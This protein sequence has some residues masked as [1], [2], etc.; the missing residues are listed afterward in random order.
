M[1]VKL[2]KQLR[3]LFVIKYYPSAGIYK[4]TTPYKT[5][6]GE[7]EYVF[8]DKDEAISNKRRLILDFGRQYYSRYRK[9][10]KII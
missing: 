1:K 10:I 3:E 6:E 2:L 9:V 7:R 8:Y 4:L 5:Y